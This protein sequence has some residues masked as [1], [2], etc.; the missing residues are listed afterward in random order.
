MT[1]C[2]WCGKTVANPI[3]F[4]RAMTGSVPFCCAEHSLMYEKRLKE[5]EAKK[6][7]WSLIYA[8]VVIGTTKPVV[9]SINHFPT[10]IECFEVKAKSDYKLEEYESLS[11]VMI[12]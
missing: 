4:K 8:I 7:V 5:A 2:V 6:I 11:C 1:S 10:F 12:K 9:Y 3:Y